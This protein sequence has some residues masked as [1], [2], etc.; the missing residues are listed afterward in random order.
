MYPVNTWIIDEATFDSFVI[1]GG[2]VI[3]ISD[4]PNQRYSSCPGVVTAGVLLP[5]ID[6]IHAELDGDL[7]ASQGMY[8]AYL[9]SEGVFQHLS[10]ILAAIMQAP[11]GIMFG[12]DELNMN[13]PRFLMEFLYSRFGLVVGTEKNP[14]YIEDVFMPYNLALLYVSN[15]IDYRTFME[16]HPPLPIND[17]VIVKMAYDINPMIKDKTMTGYMSYFEMVKNMIHANGGRFILDPMEAV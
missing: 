4:E 7:I 6:A 15:L 5:P 13:F 1:S 12:K 11:V 16:R 3:Y 2:K 14:S 10:V 17:M 9:Q 8:S